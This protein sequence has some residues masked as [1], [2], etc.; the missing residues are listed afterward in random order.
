MAGIIPGMAEPRL[1]NNPVDAA[2][3]DLA[4]SLVEATATDRVLDVG[5]GTGEILA[6]ALERRPCSG[7]GV[8]PDIG[9]LARA[10]VRMEAVTD[11]VELLGCS[12]AEADLE[13]GSFAAAL[14]VGSGHA[15][16]DEADSLPGAL[17]GLERLVRP[18]GVV[19]LGVGY[20]RR[21]PAAAYLEA[22]GLQACEMRS[23][24]ETLV[25]VRDRG[26]E[27]LA[28]VRSSDAAWDRFESDFWARAEAAARESPEDPALRARWERV[29]GWRDAY[30]RWGRSTMGFVLLVLRTPV[31]ASPR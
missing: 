14:C 9:A 2:S 16:A 10:R 24:D 31:I 3:I 21:P 15:F 19:V 29:R 23:L 13:P 5:C 30:L 7:V 20:W 18:G 12:L 27:L 22:T 1:W 26:M 11:R 17:R 6:R 8:D 28:C 25:L 4:L